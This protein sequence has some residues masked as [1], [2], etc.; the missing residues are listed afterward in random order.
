MKRLAASVR[1]SVF[2]AVQVLIRLV[3]VFAPV[4][5]CAVQLN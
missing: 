1:E 5:V 4:I 3:N 2:A